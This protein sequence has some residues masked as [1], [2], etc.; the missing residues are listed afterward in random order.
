MASNQQSERG[1]VPLGVVLSAMLNLILLVTETGS[2]PVVGAALVGAAAAGL[3]SLCRN[4]SSIP[5]SS[6]RAGR[7]TG[8]PTRSLATLQRLPRD[9][10]LRVRRRARVGTPQP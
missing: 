9:G 5:T 6:P 1:T 2:L 8:R 4:T 7:P 10:A 3:A